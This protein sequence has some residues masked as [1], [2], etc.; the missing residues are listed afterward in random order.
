MNKWGT[1]KRGKPT[2]TEPTGGTQTS[3]MKYEI[4]NKNSKE[5]RM[6]L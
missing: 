5:H 4:F 1:D 2:F 3:N 6:K